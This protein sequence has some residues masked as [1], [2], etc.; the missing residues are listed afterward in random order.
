MAKKNPNAGKFIARPTSFDI[1]LTPYLKNNTPQSDFTTGSSNTYVDYTESGYD[2]YQVSKE[3]VPVLDSIRAENQGFLPTLGNAIGRA[4][5][6]IIPTVIGNAASILDFEDYINQDAEVGNNITKAMEDFKSSINQDVFPIYRRNPNESLDIGDSAWWLENGGSLV[7][8]I[9]AFAITGAGLGAGFNLLGKGLGTIQ[10][11]SQLGQYGKAAATILSSTALNQAESITTAMQ[12]YD[13]TIRNGG[14]PQ[15]AAEA[16]AYSININRANILLNLTSAG[17]FIRS[18]KLTR[19]VREAFG[20]NLGNRLLSE[21]GQE[22]AEESINFLAQ[23]EGERFGE[24]VA[25]KRDY[26]YDFSKSIDDLLSAE[27]FEAGLLGFIGGVGQTAVTHKYNKLIGRGKE[28]DQLF[29][30][31]QESLNRIDNLAYANNLK[32]VSSVFKSIEE[33]TKIQ[34]DIEAAVEANDDLKANQLKYKLFQ[35]Q[36]FDAFSNGTTEQLEN[37]YK[38]IQSL[39]TEEAKIKGL[40]T[41]P[42][43]EFYYKT[44]AAEAL[45]AI[46]TFEDIYNEVIPKN[47]LNA[48]EV[49]NNLIENKNL[50]KQINDLRV[51]LADFKRDLLSEKLNLDI[52]D[53]IDDDKSTAIQNL[54]SYKAYKTIE[55]HM[56]S[57]KNQLKTNVSN[58][59]K[60]TSTETQKSILD[61]QVAEE[62]K[63]AQKAAKEARKQEEKEIKSRQ[64]EVKKK[65]DK[66]EK[67]KTEEP[68]LVEPVNVTE[69]S[70]KLDNL[71]KLYN[72]AQQEYDEANY[73]GTEEEYN[74][75]L[76]KLQQIGDEIDKIDPNYFE[77]KR[78]ESGFTFQTT[79]ELDIPIPTIESTEVPEF[80]ISPAELELTDETYLTPE[81]KAVV[82]I[83]D[84]EESVAKSK[85]EVEDGLTKNIPEERVL[86]LQK[87]III[88]ESIKRSVGNTIISLNINYRE[89][90]KLNTLTDTV[91]SSIE[92]IFT[93]D[94]NLDIVENFDSRLQDPNQFN[95]GTEVNIIIPTYQDILSKGVQDYLE[96][97]YNTDIQS[98]ERLPI[99]FTDSTGKIIGYLPTTDNV[100]KRV[101]D[102]NLELEIQKNKELREFISSNKDKSI[103]VKIT[104]KSSG[105]PLFTL[106]KNSIY[107]GLGNGNS[108]SEDVNIAIVKDNKLQIGINNI[109]NGK[110][111]NPDNLENGVVYS[112]TPTADG[113]TYHVLPMEVSNIGETNART[114]LTLLQLYKANPSFKAHEQ[115]IN[116]RNELAKEIDL[117]SLKELTEALESILYINNDNDRYMLKLGEKNLNL[118]LTS[119]KTFAWTDVMSDDTIQDK[120]VE[121]LSKRYY[122]VKLADFGKRFNQYKLVE[123]KINQIRHN[124]YFDYLNTESVITTNLKGQPIEGTD[125]LYFT[126]Q[127]VI[128]FTDPIVGDRSTTTEAKVEIPVET[129]PKKVSR[130]G[131]NLKR[132]GDS[133]SDDFNFITTI[134]NKSLDQQAEEL[135][136]HCS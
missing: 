96:S 121:I 34:K 100:R 32:D 13:N 24:A 135:M 11:L 40:D 28:E 18:P 73:N 26:K 62:E 19:Q 124:N 115:L 20:T 87:D 110:L 36:V 44:K 25:K 48:G 71:L 125:K 98:V 53:S 133:I 92:D 126:A 131:T 130:L 56:N 68:E 101:V 17:A 114:V 15:D 111:K 52:E 27:G 37:T 128:E 1:D 70:S 14:T 127:S 5:V 33:N 10:G 103:S 49:F 58:Y 78:K 59:A 106:N 46:K 97:D 72:K 3:D 132:R 89:D 79:E 9:G 90:S 91:T 94:G 83:V 122:A 22:Y 119:D 107:D 109:F 120:I 42:K 77:N 117:S 60:L 99:A 81:E 35:N 39:N 85:L 29:R 63:V 75:A 7:E 55:D 105:T 50:N 129:K 116:H 16:A 93:A 82:S 41:D 47:Y 66:I 43:S 76:A 65:A 112:I 61:T 54:S 134:D 51:H 80:T 69:K 84:H 12:V 21:G 74:K 113:S 4:A 45:D 104:R 95:T 57:L 38:D 136:K 123:G 30:Q 102:T 108:L 88:D 118:G 31:Q 23:K 67:V 86:Q 6:N 64:K 8:S 2:P